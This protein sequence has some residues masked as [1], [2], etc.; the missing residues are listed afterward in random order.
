MHKIPP[1]FSK[2]SVD[3]IARCLNK[4]H[5]TVLVNS[6]L[7][8]SRKGVDKMRGKEKQICLALDCGLKEEGVGFGS[9]KAMLDFN[10]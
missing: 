5:M 3:N 9:Q 7:P 8:Q 2:N 4:F 10:A 6:L 1:K